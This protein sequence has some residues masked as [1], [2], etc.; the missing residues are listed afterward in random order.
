MSLVTTA[1]CSYCEEMAEYRIGN[2]DYELHA[3]PAHKVVAFLEFI[4]VQGVGSWSMESHSNLG[5]PAP[6][7]QGFL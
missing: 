3:C 2:N 6:V 4:T 5:F 7:I 1:A